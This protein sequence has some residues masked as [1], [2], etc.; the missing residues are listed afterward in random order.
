M[1][2][3]WDITWREKHGPNIP[4]DWDTNTLLGC[5]AFLFLPTRWWHCGT[6]LLKSCS[7]DRTQRLSISGA[8]DVSLL[9]CTE[10]SKLCKTN[11]SLVQ[12]RLVPQAVRNC[13]W[14]EQGPHMVTG[15][16]LSVLQACGTSYRKTWPPW[17]ALHLL[18]KGWR[19]G[20]LEIFVGSSALTYFINYKDLKFPS[21]FLNCPE[22][23]LIEN[24]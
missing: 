7:K 16:S 18:R 11:F 23:C 1:K 3:K 20:F 17:I 22:K 21:F 5:L 6:E 14:T 19:P 8:A 13:M 4:F 9:N 12:G 2:T 24:T 15:V 10:E